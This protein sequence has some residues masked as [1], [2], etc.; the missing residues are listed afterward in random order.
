[1][2][3]L[4]T[5]LQRAPW[6]VRIGRILFRLR[7]PRFS[8]GVVGVVFNTDG[9]VLLVEHVFHPYSPWGLPGGWLDRGENPDETIAREMQE[10]LELLV[11]AG[12]LLMAEVSFGNHLDFAFLCFSD[13]EIGKLSSELLDYKW[14]DVSQLPRLQKFH[15]QA[16][17]KAL[18]FKKLNTVSGVFDGI[19]N[20]Q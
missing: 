10:E 8:A 2:R 11:R 6:I 18:E 4:A 12:P 1:M 5:F 3:R 9:K 7:Q 13:G 16:I 17:Q 15:F 20:S 19:F 14:C